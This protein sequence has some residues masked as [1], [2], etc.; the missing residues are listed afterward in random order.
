VLCAAENVWDSTAKRSVLYVSACAIVP[1]LLAP[2]NVSLLLVARSVIPIPRSRPAQVQANTC[3]CIQIPGQPARHQRDDLPPAPRISAIA[4]ATTANAPP[5][6]PHIAIL[7]R[8]PARPCCCTLHPSAACIA[9]RRTGSPETKQHSTRPTTEARIHPEAHCTARPPAALHCTAT[10]APLTGAP[11]AAV[12]SATLW[13]LL[14][15]PRCLSL[16]AAP[17]PGLGNPQKVTG[18]EH[19]QH[20]RKRKRKR[21]SC[22]RKPA[23]RPSPPK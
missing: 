3:T 5:S 22:P 11:S 23:A 7:S 4:P 6:S 8:L 14:W 2:I 1:E 21:D 20:E 10:H 17:R 15:L 19:Q 9:G 16:A 13:W 18:A 12:L